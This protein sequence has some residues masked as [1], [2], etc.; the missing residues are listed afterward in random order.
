MI[1]DGQRRIRLDVVVGSLAKGPVVLH[2]RL[3]GTHTLRPRLLPLRR[4]L[5]LCTHRRFV[6][7]LFPPDPR[8]SR[9]IEALRV[10]DAVTQGASLHDIAGVLFGAQRIAADDARGSDSLRSRVRRLVREARALAAGDY[11]LLLQKGV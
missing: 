6:S 3:A 2:Y 7:S 5:A 9:W 10:H 8:M 1:S 4:L 11:R